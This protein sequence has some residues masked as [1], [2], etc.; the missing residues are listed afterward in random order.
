MNDVVH[1]HDHDEEQEEEGEANIL[2]DPESILRRTQARKQR[3]V[4]RAFKKNFMP[5]RSRAREREQES[6]GRQALGQEDQACH[7]MWRQIDALAQAKALQQAQEKEAALNIALTTL[8]KRAQALGVNVHTPG[9]TGENRKT[10]LEA[11][12]EDYVQNQER[13]KEAQQRQLERRANRP[14]VFSV[15]QTFV[16]EK[17][18]EL[19]NAS[20]TQRDLSVTEHQ[21]SSAGESGDPNAESPVNGL[22]AL[23]GAIVRGKKF[24][25][26]TLVSTYPG[27]AVNYETQM[28]GMT[29]LLMAIG[30]ND[31]VA[32][33]VLVDIGADVNAE[34]SRGGGVT[35]LMYAV[36]QG[37]VRRFI[38]IYIFIYS[39]IHI[40]PH[41]YSQ[42]SKYSNIQ[43]LKYSNTQIL[44]YSSY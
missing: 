35:P 5:P 6:R 25:L 26:R 27:L 44:I 14:H 30:M 11:R 32:V 28:T 12:M 19:L 10:V 29:A 38:S 20:L 2:L 43:I 39:T 23:L 9:Q 16:T 3:H 22:T 42:I 1:D 18:Q 8:R 15:I 24:Y 13:Q 21:L 17:R 33:Q 36:D 37:K 31:L 4:Q 34:T 41:S 40:F 7:I